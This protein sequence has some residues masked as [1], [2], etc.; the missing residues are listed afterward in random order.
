MDFPKC[1]ICKDYI[2]LGFLDTIQKCDK[3]GREQCSKCTFKLFEIQICKSCLL[4][5][6]FERT[7][8]NLEENEIYFH[9]T[10]FTSKEWDKLK[11]L[12]KLKIHKRKKNK[13]TRYLK[14]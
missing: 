11:Q 13:K 1:R 12:V 10:S 5:G 3:C 9:S 8:F 2:E 7:D 14:N 6:K 4:S